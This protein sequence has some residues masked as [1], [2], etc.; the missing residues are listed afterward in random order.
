MTSSHMQDIIRSWN[1]LCDNTHVWISASILKATILARSP[2]ALFSPP[3]ACLCL[4]IML[5]LHLSSH[6]VLFGKFL[7]RSGRIKLSCCGFELAHGCTRQKRLSKIW[8]IDSRSVPCLFYS[9]CY[10]GD[11]F[12]CSQSLAT[13]FCFLIPNLELGTEYWPDWIGSRCLI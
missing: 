4:N 10:N 7:G 9:T 8:K 2:P 13:V 1:Y 5:Q 6:V 12:T 11:P 3:E